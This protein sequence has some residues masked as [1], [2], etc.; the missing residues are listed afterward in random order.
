MDRRELLKC[1]DRLSE[2]WK[3]HFGL[4]THYVGYLSAELVITLLYV[5]RTSDPF[6][7]EDLSG[8]EIRSLID[9]RARALNARNELKLA[10]FPLDKDIDDV[11]PTLIEVLDE[12]N[13]SESN[14][15]DDIW[16]E[17]ISYLTS[18]TKR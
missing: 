16:Q 11:M 15:P 14:L 5:W 13:L 3:D 7:F 9:D 12:Y 17:F 1:V 18:K 6:D 10:L 2:K 8:K 4:Y